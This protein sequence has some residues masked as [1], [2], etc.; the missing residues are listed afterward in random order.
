MPAQQDLWGFANRLYAVP[1]I[2]E[3]C[4]RLQDESNVDVCV[5][6]L[7]LWLAQDRR[8]VRPAQVQMILRA[9]AE[10]RQEVVQPLR[11]M[12]RWLKQGPA[13]VEAAHAH[14]LRDL[15][16]SAELRAEKLQLEALAALY[17]ESR[18]CE[19]SPDVQ[20]AVQ[21][22]LEAYEVALSATFPAEAI[23]VIAAGCEELA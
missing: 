22:S 11:C 9:S 3:V 13:L 5:L 19:Q 2:S 8:A 20:A 16:K 17:G 23:S 6:M 12:R 18:V 10:W 21:R 4:L 15:I 7:I 1:G 14:A